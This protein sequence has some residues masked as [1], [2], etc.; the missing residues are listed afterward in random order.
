MSYRS[1]FVPEQ[2][3]P[4]DSEQELHGKG[5]GSSTIFPRQVRLQGRAHYNVVGEETFAVQAD[6]ECSSSVACEGLGGVH[7]EV[8]RKGLLTSFGE[9]DN[10]SSLFF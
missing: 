5:G 4:P 1:G 9:D 10:L 8:R 3:H 2:L 7:Q 6:R